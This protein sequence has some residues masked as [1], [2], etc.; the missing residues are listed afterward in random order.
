[1]GNGPV[2]VSSVDMGAGA[3]ASRAR[4]SGGEVGVRFGHE[5][6]VL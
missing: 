6:F 2:G 1:V 4:V 5:R 3:G